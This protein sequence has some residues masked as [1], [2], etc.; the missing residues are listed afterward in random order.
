VIL[1]MP[2]TVDEML[3]AME[4]D[5]SAEWYRVRFKGQILLGLREQDGSIAAYSCTIEDEAVRGRSPS[6]GESEGGR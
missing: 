2:Q 4:A 5:P 6:S 3:D 1:G